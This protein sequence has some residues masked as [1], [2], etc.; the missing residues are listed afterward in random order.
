[1]FSYCFKAQV[2]LCRSE[3]LRRGRHRTQIKVTARVTVWR[4][5]A[6]L[7]PHVHPASQRSI[8][9]TRSSEGEPVAA[10][11]RCWSTSCLPSL[12]MVP[13]ALTLSH[14]ARQ[15]ACIDQAPPRLAVSREGRVHSPAHARTCRGIGAATEIVLGEKEKKGTEDKKRKTE[16]A[17]AQGRKR[18]SSR[19]T[20]HSPRGE[21]QSAQ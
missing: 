10:G 21:Q 16:R 19:G 12:S 1:M 3:C 8:A 20:A 5:S 13:S 11:K 14:P 7:L 2:E 15:R 4:T 9:Q 6:L 18:A 17:P